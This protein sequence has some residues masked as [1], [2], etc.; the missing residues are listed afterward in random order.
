MV[1]VNLINK[2]LFY[3]LFKAEESCPTLK[4]ITKDRYDQGA[5][6]INDIHNDFHLDYTISYASTFANC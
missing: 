1:N 6:A 2:Y 3:L 5:G 4:L